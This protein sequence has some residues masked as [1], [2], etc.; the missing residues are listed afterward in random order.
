MTICCDSLLPF[1][2]CN[3][4]ARSQKNP[5]TGKSVFKILWKILMSGSILVI[6]LSRYIDRENCSHV[7]CI[8]NAWLHTYF[9]TGK[10]KTCSPRVQLV[11]RHMLQRWKFKLVLIE[12]WFRHNKWFLIC[13]FAWSGVYFQVWFLSLPKT[14]LCL[15]K[16][17]LVAWYTHCDTHTH[18]IILKL[19]DALI[20]L[21]QC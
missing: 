6:I 11:M 17:R 15:K 14:K 19:N 20:Y 10:L 18:K 1:W 13:Q 2:I 3:R 8:M 5:I 12:C 9:Q 4:S 21:S 7:T 16:C